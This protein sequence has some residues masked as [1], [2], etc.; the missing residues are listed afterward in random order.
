MN[1]QKIKEKIKRIKKKKLK[2]KM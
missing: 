2:K 1:L